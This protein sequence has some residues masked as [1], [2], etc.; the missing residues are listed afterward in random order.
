MNFQIPGF[1]EKPG[2][3]S[4]SSALT[5]GITIGQDD[6]KPIMVVNYLTHANQESL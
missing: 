6:S 2:I 5:Y 1:S 3:F 4:Q